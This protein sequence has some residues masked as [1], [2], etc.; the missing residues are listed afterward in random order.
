LHVTPLLAETMEQT[1]VSCY[2]YGHV[3]DIYFCS[4]IALQVYFLS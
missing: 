1:L 4:Q 3:N 2:Y